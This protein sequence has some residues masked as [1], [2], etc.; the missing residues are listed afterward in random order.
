MCDFVIVVKDVNEEGG[1]AYENGESTILAGHLNYLPR[2][3]DVMKVDGEYYEVIRVIYNFDDCDD[4]ITIV[5]RK[6]VINPFLK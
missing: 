1:A 3:H 6:Y 4:P 2:I 5:V